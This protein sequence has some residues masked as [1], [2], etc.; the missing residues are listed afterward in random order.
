[1]NHNH[2]IIPYCLVFFWVSRPSPWPWQVAAV[3]DVPFC[4]AEWLSVVGCPPE[5]HGIS[6]E[7]PM[8]ILSWLTM[9]PWVGKCPF[10]GIC[11]TSPS[12]I[13][14]RLYPQ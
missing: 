2:Y 10:W 4:D 12:Y 1:M 9:A 8:E 7:V 3:V 13:C 11:F 14:W 5:E 6:W